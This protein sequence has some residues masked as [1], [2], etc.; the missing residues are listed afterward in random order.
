VL[1][2]SRHFDTFLGGRDNQP[3]YYTHIINDRNFDRL[4]SL[5]QRTSGKIV[6]GGQRDRQ[7]RYFA[8]TIVTGVQPDDPL[9]S[10]EIFGPILPIVDADFDTAIAL[11]RSGEHPLAI[12]AFTSQETDKARILNETQSGGVTFNDCALHAAGRDAPFGGVGHSGQGRYHGPHGILAFSHLR[13]HTNALPAWIEPL[14]AARYPPYSVEKA[15][16]MLSPATPPFDRDG[17][18]KSSGRSKWT[19]GFGVLALSAFLVARQDQIIALSSKL[20]K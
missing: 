20:L 14:M 8:P 3:E 4:D 19:A 7:S 5:L 1:E 9:L 18:D 17:N 11:T 16:K 12:Y 6:Y 2:L 13:T 15:H 10:E